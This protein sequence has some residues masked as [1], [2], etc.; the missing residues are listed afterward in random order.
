MASENFILNFD[1]NLAPVEAKFQ[2]FVSKARAASAEISNIPA[3]KLPTINFPPA[4]N[5]QQAASQAGVARAGIQAAGQQAGLPQ[6]ELRA[7]QNQLKKQTEVATAGLSEADAAKFKQ[8]STEQAAA[9][10]KRLRGIESI[11]A[12]ETEINAILQGHRNVVKQAANVDAAALS[13][14]Q[15]KAAAETTGVASSSG[16]TAA[17][18]K[19]IAAT[20][21]E[22]K[23]SGANVAAKAKDTQATV[24]N[25]EA[26]LIEAK[27]KLEKAKAAAIERANLRTTLAAD[28][29]VLAAKTEAVTAT[30]QQNAQ[31]RAV[32][33]ADTGVL[34]AKTEAARVQALANA[35]IRKSNAANAAV[36]RSKADTLTAQAQQN[37]SARKVAA[38]DEQLAIAKAEALV[39]TRI[40]NARARG[41]AAVDTGVID[42][43]IVA[44]KQK[45]LA[46][47][48]I[49]LASAAE[50]A[51]VTLPAE[52]R[53]STDITRVKN[54]T[55]RI[56][57]ERRVQERA[58]RQA[59]RAEAAASKKAVASAV[60]GDRLGAVENAARRQIAKELS[61]TAELE[62]ANRPEVIRAKA[63]RLLSEKALTK[64]NRQ[65]LAASIRAQGGTNLR[66][67]RA[68][69]GF[70]ASSGGAGGAGAG[71]GRGFFAGGALSSLKFGL[72]SLALFSGGSLLIDS[73][74]DAEELE[75][76]LLQLEN[77]L[78]VTVGPERATAEFARLR[79]I[80]KDT[81]R[82]VGLAGSE[83]AGFAI[84]FQG[85]FGEGTGREIEGQSGTDL[86]ES[87]VFDASRFARIS[88][89]DDEIVFD[90]FSAASIAFEASAETIANAAFGAQD[91]SGVAADEIV[92][93]LGK[94]APVAQSAG[95]ELE[96]FAAIAATA[97][98]ASGAS[99]DVLAEQFGR[100]IPAV[101]GAR[102]ELLE[103]AQTNDVL[104]QQPFLDSIAQNDVAGIIRFLIDNYDELGDV[105]QNTVVDLIGSRR[106]AQ[107]LIS[108]FENSDSFTRTLEA[109]DDTTG[110]LDDRFEAFSGTFG[111]Q[112][113]RLS[114]TFRQLLLALLDAGL[115]D[116][117]SLILES[118]IDISDTA[119]ILVTAFAALAAP[120]APVVDFL[121]EMNELLGGFPAKIA[122]VGVALKAAG[123]GPA[124]NLSGVATGLGAAA[125]LPGSAATRTTSQ[126]GSAAGTRSLFANN[127]SFPG[128]AP[129]PPTTIRNKLNAS[130]IAAAAA[131]SAAAI[132]VSKLYETV[133]E[134]QDII[135]EAAA[136]LQEKLI[137]Q[138][139]EE[140]EAIIDNSNK[141]GTRFN[142]AESF[143]FGD[144]PADRAQ[145]LLDER[146]FAES[147][148]S[149]V[150]L[151]NVDDGLDEFVN[152]ITSED[153]NVNLQDVLT[154]QVE[155]QGLTVGDLKDINDALNANV[156]T[157]DE[158]RFTNIGEGP[159]NLGINTELF[160]NKEFVEFLIAESNNGNAAASALVDLFEE[161]LENDDITSLLSA[162]LAERGPTYERALTS[163]EASTQSLD[164]AKAAL[165]AGSGSSAAYIAALD[166]RIVAIQGVLDTP[167]AA[168]D[169]LLVAASLVEAQADRDKAYAEA[170]SSQTE[171]TNRIIGLREGD[172]A[173][174]QQAQLD[175]LIA[176]LQ[177]PEFTDPAARL[178]VAENIIKISESFSSAQIDALDDGEEKVALIANGVPI[179]DEARVE[180]LLSQLSSNNE[181]FAAFQDSYVAVYEKTT[182]GFL[183]NLLG[184]LALGE[185]GKARAD[186][187]IE[188]SIADARRALNDAIQQGDTGGIDAAFEL[189]QQGLDLQDVNGPSDVFGGIEDIQTV[190]ADPK[191]ATAAA[192]AAAG[193][194]KKAADERAKAAKELLEAQNAYLLALVSGDPVKAAQEQLRQAQEAVSK[195]STEAERIRGQIEVLNSERALEEALRDIGSAQSD[196]LIA[197]ANYAG[198]T[199]DAVQLSFEA[200]QARLRQV[201]S[202]FSSGNAG[203][204]DVIR[205]EAEV[206][207]SQAR[208]RDEQLAS[209]VDEYDYLFEIDAINKQQLIQYL[210][211]LKTIPDLTTEQLR[212]LDRRIKDLNSDLGQDLQFNLP[213]NIAIPTLFETRR[214]NQT[215][216]TNGAGGGYQDNRVVSIQLN[217]NGNTDAGELVE[218]LDSYL[219]NDR[220]TVSVRRY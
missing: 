31:I 3:P 95:F 85:A 116:L 185:A 135:E 174:G 86:V 200:A 58:I 18:Q 216:D 208:V 137:E 57:E 50:Q 92:N 48:Q 172:S 16:E 80:I 118:L 193:A 114:Q 132:S 142:F 191:A 169:D 215:V 143:L 23:A 4:Q 184:A 155:E 162:S 115:A 202:D 111:Q 194:A 161:T 220:S 93:F 106:E 11:A 186:A 87:Q 100:I 37:A 82:E 45:E 206:V 175:N 159:E 182:D 41:A 30:T 187:I 204:A 105:A 129:T 151:L 79:D 66:A 180:I 21:A 5:L 75:R 72:P 110:R 149:L 101:S 28:A 2:S 27:A 38:G 99:G 55:V 63:E 209:Q 141:S 104:N 91:A 34:A 117:F 77:Q 138:T 33:N 201:Q 54:A 178:K 207:S 32:A 49:K 195:A 122:L 14:K 164:E 147:V 199:V 133:I 113:A 168:Q 134:Q 90:D 76:L 136:A 179:P 22:T 25:A 152:I 109:L 148:D 88:D 150:E 153:R 56:I 62:A 166:A 19:R 170:I 177:D 68:R 156:F 7:L 212:D 131:L 144:D 157:F 43:A 81:S 59:V 74:K 154:A 163:L 119:R 210:Q 84:Q 158:N 189:I 10:R 176:N 46:A 102:V 89:L 53:A 71:T 190:G 35:E 183:R 126:I 139:N 198:R 127:P 67:N 121:R 219:G 26:S 17:L 205:A 70:D 94:I 52:L 12:I 130:P 167:G 125:R 103:L 217:V 96:E 13:A 64:Q 24:K 124:I 160:K 196:L 181:N 171:L 218:L 165:E 140:L 108:V 8:I 112:L 192:K 20:Q 83:V 213:A 42:A 51:N 69:L 78:Q 29:G 73:L 40:Q 60:E 211:Q 197:Q 123:I 61:I 39:A 65:E 146:N 36:T 120:L 107:S 98:Q 47:A 145:K 1:I 214:L 6:N 44:A 173:E 128:V 203:Q 9:A 97:Q 188:A 15:Q